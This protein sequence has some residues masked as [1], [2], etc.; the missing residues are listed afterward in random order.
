[1]F[2]RLPVLFSASY[3]L[4]VLLA[5]I[6]FLLFEPTFENNHEYTFYFISQIALSDLTSFFFILI[7]SCL[8]FYQNKLYFYTPKNKQRIIILGMIFA[9]IYVAVAYL[10]KQLV[11]RLFLPYFLNTS[12]A[13][14]NYSDR[15][16]Y[17]TISPMF[18]IIGNMWTYVV[19]TIILYCMI[20]SS[21][22]FFKIPLIDSLTKA[23][24]RQ[25]IYSA[26]QLNS[27]QN[28][29]DYRKLYAI[30]FSSIFCFV[31]NGI[32]WNI[33]FNL[34]FTID[35]INSVLGDY[36]DLIFYFVLFSLFVNYLFLYKI[37]QIFI[38]KTYSW[39]PIANLLTA[40]AITLILFGVCAS[41]M[42][43]LVLPFIFKSIVF[44][45]AWLMVCYIMLY[46]STRFSLRRYFA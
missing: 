38:I 39:L 23:S 26:N 5:H 21:R 3:Y 7:L 42:T 44:L 36:Y 34:F 17:Q 35:G 43:C 6:T 46:Y 4:I 2:Y 40:S 12:F 18:D 37:S 33:Y 11:I 32:V 14:T 13:D 20:K 31:A 29:Q 30:I 27:N 19:A 16:Y 24:S 9:L 1:M 22:K 45:L 10:L 28:I 41:I 15:H 25:L 8:F